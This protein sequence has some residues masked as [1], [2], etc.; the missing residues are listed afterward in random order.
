MVPSTDIAACTLS[1]VYSQNEIENVRGVLTEDNKHN[2]KM[3][4]SAERC[5]N[6]MPSKM[7]TLIIMR[8]GGR[9]EKHLRTHSEMRVT[10]TG[11]SILRRVNPA[12]RLT[13]TQRRSTKSNP[14]PHAG[15]IT[16]VDNSYEEEPRAVAFV[17]RCRT[18]SFDVTLYDRRT[19]ENR[20]CVPRNSVPV[21]DLF[22][23]ES[24]MNR[25][26]KIVERMNDIEKLARF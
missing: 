24:L 1:T 22:K 23:S 17:N 5:T 15:S 2:I 26:G 20:K 13:P 6:P 11:T 16:Q 18:N 4:S 10:T 7:S 19:V 9:R 3:N 8:K 25:R 21:R 14:K 12:T